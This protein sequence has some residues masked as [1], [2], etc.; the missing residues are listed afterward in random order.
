V[1]GRARGFRELLP[2]SIG[3]EPDSKVGGGEAGGDSS[4]LICSVDGPRR[5]WSTSRCRAP[6]AILEGVHETLHSPKRAHL[7]SPAPRG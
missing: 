7:L 5:S 3:G 6:S 2:R 4:P 1:E